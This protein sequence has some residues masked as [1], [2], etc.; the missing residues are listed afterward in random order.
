MCCKTKQQRPHSRD[1]CVQAYKGESRKDVC[2]TGKNSA[3][4]FKFKAH[5]DKL[6]SLKASL[7]YYCVI[8]SDKRAYRIGRIRVEINQLNYLYGRKL[9]N[10]IGVYNYETAIRNIIVIHIWVNMNAQKF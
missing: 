3:E 6:Y 5:C 9:T 8:K 4:I 7:N 10:T 1:C 2:Q